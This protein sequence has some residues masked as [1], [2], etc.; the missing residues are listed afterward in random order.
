MGGEGRARE[1]RNEVITWS[2]MERIGIERDPQGRAPCGSGV[3]VGGSLLSFF[4]NLIHLF[5]ALGSLHS[6]GPQDEC[7]A[8][9]KTCQWVISAFI[10]QAIN[11]LWSLAE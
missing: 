11:H 5:S 10:S 7:S 1:P 8:G 3:R 4:V 6:E 9:F 2:G